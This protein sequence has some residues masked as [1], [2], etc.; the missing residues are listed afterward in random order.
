MLPHIDDFLPLRNLAN[1]EMVMKTLQKLNWQ[2]R[3]ER[4]YRAYTTREAAV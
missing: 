2:R 1:L 3:Q 4:P